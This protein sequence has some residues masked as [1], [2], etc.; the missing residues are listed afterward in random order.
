MT[1]DYTIHELHE[2]FP[3]I[4]GKAIQEARSMYLETQTRNACEVVVRF[5]ATGTLKTTNAIHNDF[6]GTPHYVKVCSK[7]NKWFCDYDGERKIILDE[8]RAI[9]T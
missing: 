6:V 1:G 8:V 5:G 4:G 7:G 2:I 3:K 9:Q